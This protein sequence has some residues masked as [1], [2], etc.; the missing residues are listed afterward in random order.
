MPFLRFSR[1]KRGYEYFAIVQ[2]TNRR[3]KAG[4]QLLY[5]FRSPPNVKVGREPFDEATRL[6]LEAHYPNLTFEWDTLAATPPPAAEPERWRERRN[7]ERAAK[8]AMETE[9]TTPDRVDVQTD[10]PRALDATVPPP[11]PIV[12]P[13]AA[14]AL[15]ES[16]PLAEALP[17]SAR[18]RRR[19]R[20]GRRGRQEGRETQQLQEVQEVQGVQQVLV[21][22]VQ[23]VHVQD[24][25][26]GVQGVRNV[27]EVNEVQERQEV[28][29]V[30]EA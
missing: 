5:A 10:E 6:A 12:V 23:E 25:E 1:D 7:M 15:E 14:S 19:R 29:E 30:V 4:S 26:V 28:H 24:V 18:P 3:G 22:E 8:L 9:S 2:P 20:R 11:E 16:A 27:D 17:Q 21:Q 13:Q